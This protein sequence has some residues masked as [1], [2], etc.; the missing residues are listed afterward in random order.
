MEVWGAVFFPV[1]LGAVMDVVSPCGRVL[2]FLEG[3]TRSVKE[4]CAYRVPGVGGG[5]YGGGDG[6]GGIASEGLKG[7]RVWFLGEADRAACEGRCGE[8]KGEE[9]LCCF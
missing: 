1:A 5:W 3:E 8:Q 2:Y 9:E 7:V 6:G 4:R